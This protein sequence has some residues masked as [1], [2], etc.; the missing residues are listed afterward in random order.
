MSSINQ[1]AEFIGAVVRQLPRDLA[2]AQMQHYID[3]Q[4]ALA[5]VQASFA[6]LTLPTGRS[7]LAQPRGRLGSTLVPTLTHLAVTRST[8]AA[9]GTSTATPTPATSGCNLARSINHEST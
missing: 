6:S 2:P 5:K 3:D 7:S 8:Q 9:F 1:F 4:A